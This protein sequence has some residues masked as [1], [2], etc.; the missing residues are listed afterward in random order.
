MGQTIGQALRGVDLIVAA[1]TFI[2][3]EL[4]LSDP[5]KFAQAQQYPGATRSRT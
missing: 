2:R 3:V 1:I 4:T 5:E